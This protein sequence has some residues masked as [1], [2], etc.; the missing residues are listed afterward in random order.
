MGNNILNDLN[1]L[2]GEDEE[3]YV[4]NIFE[5]IAPHY[6]GLTKNELITEAISGNFTCRSINNGP[7]MLKKSLKNLFHFLQI[8]T[9]IFKPKLLEYHYLQTKKNNTISKS[10]LISRPAFFIL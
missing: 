9:P 5:R 8:R 4:D 10:R 2:I 7:K 1:C 3:V 6:P